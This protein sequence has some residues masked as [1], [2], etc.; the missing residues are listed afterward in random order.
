MK[1]FRYFELGILFLTLLFASA[2][3]A[4]AQRVALQSVSATLANNVTCTG[5]AQNFTTAQG[6]PGFNNIGQTSHLATAVSTAATFTLEIDGLDNLG[7]VFR[8]SNLQVGVPTTAK[9]GLVVSAS[10]YMTNIQVSVTCTAGATFSLSYTGSFSPS[11][12]D[13]GG[14]LL[15]ALDKLPFQS[16]AANA[17]SSVTF[18]TPNGNSSG[19]I[20]FQYAAAGPSGS[21]I[22]VQCL[23]NAGTNLSAYT[24]S[25]VTGT[26]AQ[27]LPVSASSCPFVT[28]TY[29]SG[30][31]SAT[32]YKLEYVFNAIGSQPTTNDPCNSG[33]AK[34]SAAIS[35]TTATTTQ[36]VAPLA[37]RQIFVCGITTI[38][39]A[40]GGTG[41]A[42]W[43][44]GT[45]AACGTGTTTLSGALYFNNNI[46]SFSNAGTTLLTTPAGNA[47][48]IVTVGTSTNFV[49]G[50][51]T[52]VQQ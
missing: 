18:Q 21:T 51:V 3:P 52:Y 11:P 29:T 12:P 19:T 49:E 7:N 38:L 45:G 24:F 23:S 33:A 8:L 1:I 9:G 16:A 39:Q 10:G 2:V 30:G 40:L 41:T 14:T 42:Q 34:Q 50:W 32:T 17:N 48:C 46:I 20:I 25:L 26:T 31:A 15:S 6:I 44:Y 5:V 27:L 28:L 4:R 43:E 36:I 13:V 35:I 22:G 37:G 47:L